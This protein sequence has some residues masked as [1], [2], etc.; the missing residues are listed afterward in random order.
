MTKKKKKNPKSKLFLYF[1]FFKIC[2][3]L[4][5]S[6]QISNLFSSKFQH[7]MISIL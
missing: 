7:L 5:T 6:V 1:I 3:I 4:H 2:S